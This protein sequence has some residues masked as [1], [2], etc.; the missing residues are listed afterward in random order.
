MIR[1]SGTRCT[2]VLF[3]WSSQL[4]RSARARSLNLHEPCYGASLSSQARCTVA[5]VGRW[6]SHKLLLHNIPLDQYAVL[7]VK[8]KTN[9][10]RIMICLPRSVVAYSL[11]MLGDADCSLGRINRG[12]PCRQ[13][14]AMHT[15]SILLEASSLHGSARIERK[16]RTGS[17]QS[18]VARRMAGACSAARPRRVLHLQSCYSHCSMCA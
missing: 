7:F 9:F 11:R 6:H 3:S 5:L 10:S 1:E 2:E 13:Q 16:T 17:R 18:Y 14:A 15:V 8:R 12:N 4:L